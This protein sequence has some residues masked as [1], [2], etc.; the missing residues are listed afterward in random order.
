MDLVKLNLMRGVLKPLHEL[1][2]IRTMV[3]YMVVFKSYLC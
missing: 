2:V 3:A 1:T